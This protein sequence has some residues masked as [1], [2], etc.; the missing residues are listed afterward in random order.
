MKC[1]KCGETVNN[2]NHYYIPS[3]NIGNNNGKG[4][5]YCIKCAKEENIITLV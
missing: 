3:K 2:L 5:R 4:L 1:S